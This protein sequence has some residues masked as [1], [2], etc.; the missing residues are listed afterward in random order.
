MHQILARIDVHLREV[1]RR[2]QSNVKQSLLGS[3][4]RVME[5]TLQTCTGHALRLFDFEHLRLLCAFRTLDFLSLEAL[6]S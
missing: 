6:S 1:L 2:L 4:R 3:C 5:F